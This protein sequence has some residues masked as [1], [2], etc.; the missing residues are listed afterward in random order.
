M[1]IYAVEWKT[2]ESGEWKFDP[3][4]R[5]ATNAEDAAAN[6]EYARTL[7]GVDY[8]IRTYVRQEDENDE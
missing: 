1:K 6:L 5:V 8:R 3:A 4:V 2:P 7:S